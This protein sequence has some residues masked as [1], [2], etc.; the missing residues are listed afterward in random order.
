[1]PYRHTLLFLLAALTSINASAWS[2]IADALIHSVNG[3]PC[4][5]ITKKEEARNGTPMLGALIV[6]DLS[7]QPVK[8][9]WSFSAPPDWPIP[10]HAASCIRYGDL[11][12]TATGIKPKSLVPGHFYS[13]FLNGRPKDPSDPTYGYQ[14][15]FCVK[16]TADGG[17]QV[18]PIN[19][20]MQ[21]WIDEV[22]PTHP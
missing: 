17:Q 10:I 3:M 6:S 19:S 11:P 13:V 21:A 8:K 14:G 22:C 20:D 18:I 16:A 9:V 12:P 15:K 1:M 4:F 5:S 7:V 2:R